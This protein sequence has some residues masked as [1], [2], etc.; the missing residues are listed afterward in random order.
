[1][2]QPC[3]RCVGNSIRQYT[4]S[5]HHL[6]QGQLFQKGDDRIEGNGKITVEFIR[7]DVNQRQIAQLTCVGIPTND[8]SRIVEVLGGFEFAV[9]VTAF[10]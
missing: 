8:V 6:F 5:P 4:Q 10:A 1:V 2:R 7:R 9:S 3:C